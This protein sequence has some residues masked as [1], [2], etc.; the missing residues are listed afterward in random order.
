MNVNIVGPAFS[1]NAKNLPT[2]PEP[3]LQQP[4]ANE[5]ISCQKV[6]KPIELEELVEPRP[7]LESAMTVRREKSPS[8]IVTSEKEIMTDSIAREIEEI[9]NSIEQYEL[10]ITSSEAYL[11]NFL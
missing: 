3:I 11:I 9:D 6:E 1:Y 2:K 7:S 10:V 4:E 5:C 8:K